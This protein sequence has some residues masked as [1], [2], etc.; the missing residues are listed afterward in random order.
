MD[1]GGRHPARGL[2]APGSVEAGGTASREGAL[3]DLARCFG[4]SSCVT[5]H[6]DCGWNGGRWL[7]C[8]RGGSTTLGEV[9]CEAGDWL[10]ADGS[11][12]KR[13]AI[14]SVRCSVHVHLKSAGTRRYELFKW[15]GSRWKGSQ[16]NR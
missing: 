7:L 15:V 8:E 13:A 2:P 5:S 12:T 10:A 9:S 14:T 1:R 4:A 3:M 16:F 6:S 11:H